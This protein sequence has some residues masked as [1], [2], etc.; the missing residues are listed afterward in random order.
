MSRDSIEATNFR[1]G[2][3]VIDMQ[4]GFVSKGGSYDHLGMNIQDYQKVIPKVKELI[5]F[6]RTKNIPIFYTEAVREASGID[7]LTRFHRLLPLAREERLKVPIT[8][9]GTWDAQTIDEIKPTEND[10]IVIKRRDGA[11]QDTELRVW[12]QSEGIN[13]L[14][15]CGIDT[16]ICVE[17]SLREAFNIG[18]DV[19]LVSDSTASGNK[20]HYETTLER[21]RD[22]YG[23]VLDTT[24]FYKLINS[25]EDLESGKLDYNKLGEKYE[26][27]LSEFSLIDVRKK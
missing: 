12:L 8:V 15:F 20:R 13:T 6:C 27:F 14:V 10:H 23:L 18:Y 16:S 4:N 17:T 5:Q 7:L 2:L 22:Y 26:K 3:V 24:R 25:L 21:V 1:F 19:I 9:R 11:F